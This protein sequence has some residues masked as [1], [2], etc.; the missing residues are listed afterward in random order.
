MPLESSG[1][2]STKNFPS[3]KVPNGIRS[4]S[5]SSDNSSGLTVE[6]KRKRDKGNPK[7]T[8]KYKIN[9]TLTPFQAEL[10]VGILLGDCSIPATISKLGGYRLTIRHSMDQ[11]DY[12]QHINELFEAFVVQPLFLSSSLDPR[13][14]KT[15][16]WCNLHTLYF[17][18]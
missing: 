3:G 2:N 5:T 7:Y 8:S 17:P 6:G 16:S 15:Y 10:L 12:L 9:Q 18:C 4:Y 11:F 13:T 14:K 1:K